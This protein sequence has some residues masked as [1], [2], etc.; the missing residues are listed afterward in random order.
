MQKGPVIRN[1]EKRINYYCNTV[2]F[3]IIYFD[4]SMKTDEYFFVLNYVCLD[5]KTN[6]SIFD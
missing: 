3:Y 2:L 1:E 5:S 6:E 4:L